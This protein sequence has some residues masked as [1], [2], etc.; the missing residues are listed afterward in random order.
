MLGVQNTKAHRLIARAR[1]DGLIRV[2][3]E[4]PIAGCMALE[5]PLKARFGLDLARSSPMSMRTD[6]PLR[7]LGIAGAATSAT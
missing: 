3:V 2:F 6:L 7:T 4:G 1:N 5:E